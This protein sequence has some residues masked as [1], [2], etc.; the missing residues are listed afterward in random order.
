M[1]DHLVNTIRKEN[2][3]LQIYMASG[4]NN[5]API[6]TGKLIEFIQ[7]IYR[8]LEP[9]HFTGKLIIYITFDNLI[10]FPA[11][12]ATKLFDK[13]ILINSQSNTIVIQLFNGGE[14]PLLWENIVITD[15]LKSGN[16]ICYIYENQ[17]EHFSVGS[18]VID[19]VNQFNSASIYALQYHYLSEAL[20]KYKE[21]KVKNASCKLFQEALYDRPTR[22]YF[23]AGPEEKMQISLEQYLISSLR[24]VDVVREYNLGASKPVDVRVYWKSGN[25]A[26]LI[27]V[28]WL[29]Q[30][31]DSRGSLST[32]YSNARGNE[33]MRQIKEYLDLE[34]QDTPTC[35]TKGYLVVIDGRRR[36]VN[37]LITSINY[38]DGM[39][40]SNKDLELD[41]DKKYYER[42]SH[43]EKP[44]RMFV[45]PICTL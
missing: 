17:K 38:D 36:R 9:S 37:P 39:Y 6:L 20:V 1:S 43:I 11:Q 24:G 18:K 30:S 29:G 25:R 8:S 7:D 15:E 14:L 32:Q 41:A 23:I 5:A 22:I 45:N 10:L 3:P 31:V 16:A 33:G 35:I 42:M 12:N 27:E 2:Y 19:I 26:A 28:K 13:N 40:Y 34:N 4:N 44:M 21:E